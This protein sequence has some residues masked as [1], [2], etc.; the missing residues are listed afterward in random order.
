MSVYG[1]S[2]RRALRATFT[3]MKFQFS[4]GWR[5]TF[6]VCLKTYNFMYSGDKLPK[7]YWKEGVNCRKLFDAY[8]KDKGL[9][10]SK[11]ANWYEAD[12]S[13]LREMKVILA[14]LHATLLFNIYIMLRGRGA[15]EKNKEA[16]GGH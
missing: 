12:L 8:A 14:P 11:V 16:L 6:C 9:D 15:C 13:S 2:A 3:D 1:G 10:P 4:S 7:G 5:E